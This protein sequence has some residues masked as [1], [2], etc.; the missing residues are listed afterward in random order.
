MAQT[1]H[2]KFF[3]LP[4]FA[5]FKLGVAFGGIATSQIL[6]KIGPAAAQVGTGAVLTGIDS[7]QA[8]THYPEKFH[9]PR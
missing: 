5:P 7:H 8:V 4:F 6:I 1:L 2:T 3:K 9:W